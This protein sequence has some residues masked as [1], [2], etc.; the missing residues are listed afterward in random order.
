MKIIRPWGEVETVLSEDRFQCNLLTIN[1]GESTFSHCHPKCTEVHT[2]IQG[3]VIA[4]RDG[5][6]QIFHK[7]QSM[8]RQNSLNIFNK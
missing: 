6:E 4:F 5:E 1:P 7:E 8:K 3:S 2:V